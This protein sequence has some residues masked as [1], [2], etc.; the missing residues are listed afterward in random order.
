MGLDC[1]KEYFDVCARQ[2]SLEHRRG[3]HHT[4]TQG[5]NN[6]QGVRTIDGKCFTTNFSRQPDGNETSGFAI[7][8]TIAR[9]VAWN[10][11]GKCAV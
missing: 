7:G 2:S 6:R 8:L 1:I 10:N 5:V 3:D 11:I 9:R 4:H